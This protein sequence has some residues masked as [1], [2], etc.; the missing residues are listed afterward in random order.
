MLKVIGAD[1][2]DDLYVDVPPAAMNARL[3]LPMSCPRYLAKPE[4]LGYK[5]NC[6]KSAPVNIAAR[7]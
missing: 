1:K 2:I 6:S 3:N 4:P 5:T 7:P